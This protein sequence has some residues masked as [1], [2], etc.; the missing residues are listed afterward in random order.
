MPLNGFDLS[1]LA[2]LLVFAGIGAWR[3]LV[4]EAVSLA[5]WVL[6]S[7]LSWLYAADLAR[8]FDGLTSDPPLRQVL[9]FAVI[10][11]VVFIVGAVAGVLLHR[12]LLR[13]ATFRVANRI[14]GGFIGLARGTAVILIVFL[15]AGLTNYPQRPWWR[16]A[17]LAPWFE[18]VALYAS[19]YIPPDVARHIRYG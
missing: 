2:L 3:G 10:F 16:A 8:V 7:L 4:R 6:A 1:L 15:L 13:N 12:F 18:R 5:T 11:A 19:G 17:L 14:F 9:A